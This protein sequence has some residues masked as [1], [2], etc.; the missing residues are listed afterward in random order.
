MSEQTKTIG[1]Y[2]ARWA[3]TPELH[4]LLNID[5]ELSRRLDALE[6][7]APSPAGADA[8]RLNLTQDQARELQRL[9]DTQPPG[10][11]EIL[12]GV[13]GGEQ[14]SVADSLRIQL[15]AAKNLAIQN[16]KE[17]D[18][19]RGQLAAAEARAAEAE[20]KAARLWKLLD[21]ID[22]LDDSEKHDNAAFRNKCYAAQRKRFDIM[23]GGDYDRISGDA[24]QEALRTPP[25]PAGEVEAVNVDDTIAFCQKHYP[26]LLQRLADNPTTN[27]V[28]TDPKPDAP[29]EWAMKAACAS[30]GAFMNTGGNVLVTEIARIIADEFAR[31]Q[32]GGKT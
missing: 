25:S 30:L 5:L 22:T 21:D 4:H 28:K 27:T 31:R 24:Q 23:S 7:P 14:A 3:Y 32:A 6:Q 29:P 2:L 17:V 13:A 20:Q 16:A 19:L 15:K 9:L 8:V 1:S 11:V 10:R 12:P 26:N 18:R